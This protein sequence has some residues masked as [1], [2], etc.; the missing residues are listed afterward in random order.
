M[1]ASLFVLY[2][3]DSAHIALPVA[4]AIPALTMYID[5]KQSVRCS[6]CVKEKTWPIA[7]SLVAGIAG[8][9]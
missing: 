6:E 9:C 8:H 1:Y 7:V 5:R 3:L 4:T 2:P